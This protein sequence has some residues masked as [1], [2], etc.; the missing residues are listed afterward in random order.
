MNKKFKLTVLL[1]LIFVMISFAQEYLIL[2][3]KVADIE[4]DSIVFTKPLT[5][6]SIT[7]DITLKPDTLYIWAKTEDGVMMSKI[8]S[9]KGKYFEF[10]NPINKLYYK[11]FRDKIYTK[12]IP[13]LEKD[14]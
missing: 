3:D 14:E 12:I 13:D 8:P 11:T 10:K 4:I 1:L 5:K 7:T 9:G 2:Y 6:F